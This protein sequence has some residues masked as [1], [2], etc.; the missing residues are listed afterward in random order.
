M[1]KAHDRILEINVTCDE[2]DDSIVVTSINYYRDRAHLTDS[3]PKSIVISAGSAS[4]TAHETAFGQV[5]P[6]PTHI[7]LV[8]T[9]QA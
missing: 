6:P 4:A 1:A 2:S 8:P 5:I 7:R 9:F 3:D